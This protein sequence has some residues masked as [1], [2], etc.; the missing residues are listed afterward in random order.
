MRY[1]LLVLAMLIG[2]NGPTQASDCDLSKFTKPM[3]PVAAAFA[4]TLIPGLSFKLTELFFE[5]LDADENGKLT[6]EEVR[7]ADN[8]R[9]AGQLKMAACFIKMDRNADGKATRAEV[10]QWLTG[11]LMASLIFAQSAKGHKSTEESVK[12]PK[13]TAK[14]QPPKAVKKPP[15]RKDPLDSVFKTVGKLKQSQQSDRDRTAARTPAGVKTAARGLRLTLSEIQAV[16]RQIQPCWNF[17]AGAQNAGALRV[18]ITIWLNRDGSVR[19]A[20]ILDGADT[21]RNAK[22]RTAAA[23]GLRAINDP[24]CSPLKLPP[25]KFDQWKV[26]TID[27]DPSKLSSE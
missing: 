13:N 8:K 25:E 27:F 10:D 14:K 26:L 17:P 9:W 16:R 1:I 15:A 24:S 4:G 18:R 6:L 12:P 7:I 23:A 5:K 20:K 21:S 2:A 3:P 19:D 11:A 22:L